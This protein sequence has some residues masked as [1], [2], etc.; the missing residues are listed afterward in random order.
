MSAAWLPTTFFAALIDES[1]CA[2]VIR[3]SHPTKNVDAFY[4]DWRELARSAR[5]VAAVMASRVGH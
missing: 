4:A 2:S 5:E 3:A 1:D